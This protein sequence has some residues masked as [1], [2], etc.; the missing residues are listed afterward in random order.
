MTREFRNSPLAFAVSFVLGVSATG[1]VVETEL[2]RRSSAMSS[3]T[4]G[5]CVDDAG[6]TPDA[7]TQSEGSTDSMEMVCDADDC[8]A[9]SMGDAHDGMTMP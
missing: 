4:D 8:D 1:C 6:C 7:A 2:A 3:D 5:S 9:S